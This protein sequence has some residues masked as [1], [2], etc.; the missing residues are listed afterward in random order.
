MAVLA[1]VVLVGWRAVQAPQGH[2]AKVMMVV[3]DT[4]TPPRLLLAAA[5]AER[6]R[7]AALGQVLL[8]AMAA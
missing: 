6:A 1:A 3:L 2:R 7:L 4:I 5:A 8:L